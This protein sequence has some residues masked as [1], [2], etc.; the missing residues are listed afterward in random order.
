MSV[1]LSLKGGLQQGIEGVAFVALG[2]YAF[3]SFSSACLAYGVGKVTDLGTRVLLDVF[4]PD[5]SE[6]TKSIAGRSTGLLTSGTT[7]QVALSE[8]AGKSV[9]FFNTLITSLGVSAASW[10][11]STLVIKGVDYLNAPQVPKEKPS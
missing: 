8:M 6:E 3:S 11:L 4:K 7:L 10:G 1:N 2:T 5:L 9:N